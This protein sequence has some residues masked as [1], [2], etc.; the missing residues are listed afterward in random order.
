MAIVVSENELVNIDLQEKSAIGD[1]LREELARLNLGLVSFAHSGGV[2]KGSQIKYEKGERSPDAEYLVRVAAIGVDVPYVLMGARSR[3]PNGVDDIERESYVVR[4]RRPPPVTGTIGGGSIVIP[5]YE[6]GESAG[7][8]TLEN[9]AIVETLAV[10]EDFIRANRLCA[11]RVVTIQ[12]C[13][14]SMSPTL[15]LG[16]QVIVDRSVERIDTDGVYAVRL[17]GALRIR[18]FQLRA[19]GGVMVIPD[20]AAYQAETISAERVEQAVVVIGR[21]LPYKFGRIRL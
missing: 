1:R 10:S 17:A 15:E 21:V 4:A 5:R 12:V 3:V 19:D 11:D 20:N 9:E 14:S 7:A 8:I 2:Q 13:E 18:R 16:D 6:A